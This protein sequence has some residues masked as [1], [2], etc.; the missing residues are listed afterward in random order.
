MSSLTLGLYYHTIPYSHLL[1][2]SQVIKAGEE[3]LYALLRKDHCIKQQGLNYEVA[4]RQ[5]QGKRLIDAIFRRKNERG[6]YDVN[7]RSKEAELHYDLENQ[8]VIVHMRHG[9]IFGSD[10]GKPRL[11]FEDNEWA[12]ELPTGFGTNYTP[13][14]SDMV[15]RTPPQRTELKDSIRGT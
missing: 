2:R 8:Q 6:Q 1:L 4:V 11:Y 12:V 9:Q 13:R 5:V 14:A 7:A 10:D 15:G 3:M